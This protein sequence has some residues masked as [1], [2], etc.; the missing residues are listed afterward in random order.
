MQN[1]DADHLG[2]NPQQGQNPGHALVSGGLA[3]A[4]D[5]LQRRRNERL[6]GDAQSAVE[7]VPE[8][9]AMFCAGLGEAEEGVATIA[10]GVAASSCTDLA[11]GHLAADVVLGAIGVQRDFRP[12][13]HHQQLGLVGPQPRQ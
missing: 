9:H 5:E 10:S 2:Q 11:A 12:F 1:A 7:I 6:T 3:A 13:Q 4:S 8:R